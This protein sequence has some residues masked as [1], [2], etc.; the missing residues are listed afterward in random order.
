MLI[1]SQ[2]STIL[3]SE[4]APDSTNGHTVLRQAAARQIPG[5]NNEPEKHRPYAPLQRPGYALSMGV[6]IPPR[7]R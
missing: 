6:E 4:R 3:K 5:E 1:R 7:P 2:S